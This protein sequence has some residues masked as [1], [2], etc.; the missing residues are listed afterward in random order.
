VAPD[1]EGCFEINY[2][3]SLIEFEHLTALPPRSSIEM[4]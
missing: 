2:E 3:Q 4:N 1:A